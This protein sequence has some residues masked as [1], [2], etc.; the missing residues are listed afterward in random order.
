MTMG[1]KIIDSKGFNIVLAVLI[2]MAL[3][4]YVT[5]E[6]NTNTSETIYNIPVTIVNEDVLTSRGLM[7]APSSELT[8]NLKVYGNRKA[9]IRI[10]NDKESI[11]V[12][13][14][15]A[16]IQAPGTREMQCRISLP[17]TVTSGSVTVQDQ[18]SH[19]VRLVVE[20]M[21]TKQVPIVG[22]FIGT[23]AEGFRT[24]DFMITPS[25]VVIKGP[26]D[27]IKDVDYAQVTVSR[28][29]MSETYTGDQGLAY[30]DVAGIEVDDTDI[31]PDVESV[32]VVLPVAMTLDLPLDVQFIYGGGGTAD[33]FDKVVSYEVLPESIAISGAAED[34][35]PLI[36]STKIIG[37]IDLSELKDSYTFN[38][39]LDS[40]LS[41]DSGTT[42][43]TVTVKISGL[44]SKTLETNNIDI[45]N[46]PA[47]VNVDAVTQSLQVQV[48]GPA[49]LLDS[50]QEYQ[51]RAV[52]DLQ[53][54][55][56]MPGQFNQ[57]VKIYLDGD[58]QCG[59][60]GEYSIVIKVTAAY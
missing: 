21:M 34:I 45:I 26:E 17:S 43:A 37:T 35:K 19:S 52:A 28:Q 3:W 10:K 18:D 30:I 20:R 36:D 38:I 9:I 7:I 4:L 57:K 27:V 40:A 5:A 49:E 41:N 2:A 33:N 24:G 16:D 51:L 47:G 46:K 15:V 23:V 54:V 22:N 31:I 25:T 32:S 59:V 53:N 1:K 12:S 29:N 56:Q 13:I 44:E 50:V 48:R 55:A 6:V 11:A 42:E 60:V 58:G 8:V 39:V 14:D